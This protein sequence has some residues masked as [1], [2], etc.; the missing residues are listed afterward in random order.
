[1][2]SEWSLELCKIWNRLDSYALGVL[3]CTSLTFLNHF[4]VFFLKCVGQKFLFFFGHRRAHVK[5]KDA[6]SLFIST[7]LHCSQLLLLPAVWN[8]I[9]LITIFNSTH[10]HLYKSHNTSVYSIILGLR[11]HEKSKRTK[12]LT[13]SSLRT[14]II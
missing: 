12:L 3:L 14:L 10:L 2:C 13:L 7:F 5:A 8:I 1:M 11:L 9:C 6:T 4:V